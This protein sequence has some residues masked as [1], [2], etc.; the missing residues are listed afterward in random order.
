MPKQPT[1][2]PMI[3][4]I[5]VPPMMFIAKVKP[6]PNIKLDMM[7]NV[8]ANISGGFFTLLSN[9]LSALTFE[10]CFGAYSLAICSA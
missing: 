3:I 7:P 10:S 6:V 5:S 2:M 8:K 9:R 1:T 4:V